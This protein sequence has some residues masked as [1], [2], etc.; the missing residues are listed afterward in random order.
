M[1]LAGSILLDEPKETYARPRQ[2]TMPRDLCRRRSGSPTRLTTLLVLRH[3]NQD[4]GDLA[5]FSS[6]EIH[7]TQSPPQA[8]VLTVSS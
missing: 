7:P 2:D 3:I 8:T 1:G 5:L 4:L 6:K